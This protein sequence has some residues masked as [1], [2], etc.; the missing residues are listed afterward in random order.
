MTDQERADLATMLGY[1]PE[2]KTLRDFVD[3]LGMLFEEGQSEAL[4]WDRHAALIANPSFLAVPELVKAIGA[5]VAE[6][7]A[8]MIAFLASPACRRVRTNNHVER[9][10]RKLRYEE[11]ARYKWRKRRTTV[12]FLALL[13]DRYWK[14]ERAMRNRWREEHQPTVRNRS[15][16]KAG[17]N[18]R[19]A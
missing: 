12:R 16:P 14:Q 15:S 9:V 2:L 19:V 7:F 4:A 10:N 11:K 18:N 8:K 5:L 6:K 13:L 17:T 3:D 1:L